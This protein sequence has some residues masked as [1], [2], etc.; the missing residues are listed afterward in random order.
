MFPAQINELLSESAFSELGPGRILL[1]LALVLALGQILAWHYLRFAPV[2]SNK[3][4]F[5]RL[6]VFIA[7]CS[8]Q[9]DVPSG[10]RVSCE[11]DSVCPGNLVCHPVAKLCLDASRSTP[12]TVTAEATL[13]PEMGR[14]G[15]TFTLTVPRARTGEE[16]P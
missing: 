14:A 4:K 11:R 9:L 8:L 6:F 2:L 7:A 3:R 16:A 12:A 15:T 10:A 1:N 13:S 5:S